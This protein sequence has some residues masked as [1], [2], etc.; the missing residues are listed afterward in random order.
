MKMQKF[1]SVLL[2]CLVLVCSSGFAFNVHYCGEN[3]ASVSI[4]SQPVEDCV[5]PVPEKACCAKAAKDHK[6]CCSDKV[7]DLD[8]QPDVIVKS[9]FFSIDAPYIAA[10]V[11][12]LVPDSQV[13][14]VKQKQRTYRYTANSPPLFKLYKQLIFYA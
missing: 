2:A 9:V 11:F 10:D 13:F 12:R 7:V 1:T 4:G 8:D 5:D 6:S 3:I 14:P